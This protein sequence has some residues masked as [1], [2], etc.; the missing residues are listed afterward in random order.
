M[1]V[2]SVPPTNLILCVLRILLYIDLK[3]VDSLEHFTS[4]CTAYEMFCSFQEKAQQR[5]R[6]IH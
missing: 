6:N 2:Q 4:A 5:Q 3:Y 1:K